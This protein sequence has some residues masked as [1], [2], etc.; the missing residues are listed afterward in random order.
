M[1]DADR[2][3][4]GELGALQAALIAALWQA[5]SPEEVL[6]RLA[7]AP[8]SDAARRWI[9]RSDLRALQ[10]A[11]EIVRRWTEHDSDAARGG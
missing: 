1:A 3:D 5:S 10:T 11:L 4:D 6:S 2:T 9:A 7:Q 8:L